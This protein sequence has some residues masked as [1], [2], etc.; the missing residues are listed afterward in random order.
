[1]RPMLLPAL[2]APTLLCVGATALAADLPRRS[3]PVADYYSPQ[4]A[5]TWQGFY[6]GINGGY[7]LGAFQNGSKT[8]LGD[9]NGWVVGGTTGYNLTFAPNFLVGVEADFD[10]NSSKDGRS[11]FVGVSG[12]GSVDNTLTIRA[13]AGVT[14][15]RALLFVTGGFAG[16]NTSVS[17]NN[18]FQGFYGQQSKF[19]AGWAL[20]AGV[21]FGLAPNLSAKAEYLFTSVGGDR[22]FDFSANSLQTNIDTSTIRGGL[23]YHF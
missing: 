15:D 6:I 1:M 20:G 13:R 11:P 18:V 3:A 17:V 9:P 7:A 4:P 23:N 2:L 5:F 21:E 16:S 14:V 8:L 12:N 22:Y 19:L 10:F